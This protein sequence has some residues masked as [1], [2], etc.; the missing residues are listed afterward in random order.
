MVANELPV[1][2]PLPV[3]RK[4]PPRQEGP[5]AT[6]LIA[7]PSWLMVYITP[8]LSRQRPPTLR[9]T[10]LSG[11][12]CCGAAFGR[13]ASAVSTEAGREGFSLTAFR[14]ASARSLD[15][16]SAAAFFAAACSAARSSRSPP[17]G[18]PSTQ[19][20]SSRPLP[21]VQRL[22]VLPADARS[23][24]NVDK[25]STLRPARA[26]PLA[27]PKAR[28]TS[29]PVEASPQRSKAMQYA[30]EIP[31][32]PSQLRGAAPRTLALRGAVSSTRSC[33]SNSR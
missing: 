19:Q 3:D 1:T 16:R 27:L 14:A 26:W 9:C 6:T 23:P 20:R 22:P 29:V 28:P 24:A 5:S 21:A 13:S 12:L 31:V 11:E 18:R 10:T 7:F 25:R 2:V 8:Q 4:Y 17:S 30:N 15:A 32:Q 33:C